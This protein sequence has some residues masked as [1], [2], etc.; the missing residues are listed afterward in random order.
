MA[1]KAK[2]TIAEAKE[3]LKKQNKIFY[4]VTVGG[5]LLLGVLVFIFLE[6]EDKV[7]KA[8]EVSREAPF[9]NV[10]R[11]VDD[12]TW[13]MH[14]SEAKIEKSLTRAELAKNTGEKSLNRIQV[15]EEKIDELA[16]K[17]DQSDTK[18]LEE[19]IKKLEEK[20]VE[21]SKRKENDDLK[22]NVQETQESIQQ[23]IKKTSF[24]QWQRPT[25]L[26]TVS[27]NRSNLPHGIAGVTP[28]VAANVVV[29]TPRISHS[30]PELK[31]TDTFNLQSS[32]IEFPDTKTLVQSGTILRG[33]LLN[34]MRVSTGEGAQ[35]N[36]NNFT[37]QVI[38]EGWLPNY[39]QAQYK[40]CVIHGAAYGDMAS[41]RAVARLERMS[42]TWE[43]GG[44]DKSVVT[45]IVGYVVDPYGQEGMGGKIIRRDI[46]QTAR[47]FWFKFLGSMG[48]AFSKAAGQQ[49]ITPEGNMLRAFDKKQIAE[50]SVYS[51][52]G[53]GFELMAELAAKKIDKLSD[54]IEID[55]GTAYDIVIIDDS[56]LGSKRDRGK[57]D[58]PKSKLTQVF[59]G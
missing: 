29:N 7:I 54:I 53:G 10:M 17:G 57:S 43:E 22:G 18:H 55:G 31:F 48:D 24:E 47:A 56:T 44:L 34:G 3:V 59:E 28:A 36:P 42:C 45:D 20:L 21:V 26:Q 37:L 5:A 33:I 14:Q 13:W 12:K 30:M 32:S 38:T 16:R 15:L 50:T 11:G 49:L 46:E 9:F 25:H 52:M 6:E 4:G 41:E 35:V 8:E 2:N 58:S 1:N 51:G 39:K 27:P 23:T 19:K 40:D